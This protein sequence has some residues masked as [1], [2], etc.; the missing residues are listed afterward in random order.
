M[1]AHACSD[2]E[3]ELE[4]E[5]TLLLFHPT[6][7]QFPQPT[8]PPPPPPPGLNVEKSSLLTLIPYIAMTAMTPLVGPVADGLG[9]K[10]W[11]VTAVRK[12][13]QVRQA[14]GLASAGPGA[15]G[16]GFG[17]WPGMEA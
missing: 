11:S 5:A 13:S 15:L 3:R 7:H 6:P 16:G 10:G 8:P 12:L 1:P 14:G 4:P 2:R 17:W 9:E